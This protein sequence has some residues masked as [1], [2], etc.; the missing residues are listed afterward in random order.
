[1]DRTTLV[2]P[3]SRDLIRGQTIHARRKRGP[4]YLTKGFTSDDRIRGTVGR[5]Q[6]GQ[7]FGDSCL[8]R[9][10]LWAT[11]RPRGAR[12]RFSE[13]GASP[14]RTDR[15]GSLLLPIPVDSPCF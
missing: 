3:L 13:F 7:T 14:P 10:Y 11:I 4:V 5:A 1:M 6:A 8:H 9:R 2:L 15:A 12:S